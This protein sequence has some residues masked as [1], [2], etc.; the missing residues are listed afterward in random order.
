[1]LILVYCCSK[2]VFYFIFSNSPATPGTSFGLGPHPWSFEPVALWEAISGLLESYWRLPL[3]SQHF[4][5]QAQ[6][7]A[8]SEMDRSSTRP[9]QRLCGAWRRSSCLKR[10]CSGLA[11]LSC[12]W[13][14]SGLSTDI[15]TERRSHGS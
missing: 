15:S 9:D 1:M 4:W 2:S 13:V 8:P 12:F 6:K 3:E 7:K 5:C 10:S 11:L 14:C